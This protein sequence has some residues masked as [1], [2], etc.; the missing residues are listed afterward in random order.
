MK[1]KKGR[2]A[3]SEEIDGLRDCRTGS[4]KRKRWKEANKQE[5]GRKERSVGS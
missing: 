2:R 5:K 1:G 3:G 4:R